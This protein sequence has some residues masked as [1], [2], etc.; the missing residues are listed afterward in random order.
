MLEAKRARARAIIAVITAMDPVCGARCRSMGGP[1]DTRGRLIDPKDEP[2][3]AQISPDRRITVG[4]LYGNVVGDRFLEEEGCDV[5]QVWFHNVCRMVVNRRG[6]D[7]EVHFYQPGLWEEWFG[8]DPR[9]DTH[10]Y[11][12]LPFANPD[13]AEWRALEKTADFQL[14]PM[15]ADVYANLKS[16]K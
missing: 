12:R 14:K 9:S 6:D 10:T 4:R 3:K 11:C 1:S 16:I 13:S 8:V 15:R 5:I 2:W 7:L